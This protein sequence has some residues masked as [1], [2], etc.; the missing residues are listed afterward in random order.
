MSPKHMAGWEK[1]RQMGRQRFIWLFGVLGFG[2][3]FALCMLLIFYLESRDHPGFWY[4]AICVI[5]SS[6]VGGYLWGLFMWHWMES[7]Y[8]QAKVF[9]GLSKLVCKRFSESSPTPRPSEPENHLQRGENP[10]STDAGIQDWH[11]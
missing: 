1:A 10:Q 7:A 5:V 6:L 8:Q 9:N 3:S 4:V 2:V 11:D